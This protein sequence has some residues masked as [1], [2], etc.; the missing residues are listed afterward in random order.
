MRQDL[1]N[2]KS[3]SK[4]GVLA[5]RVA[6]DIVILFS[7]HTLLKLCRRKKNARLLLT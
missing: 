5:I 3:S 2:Q 6:V 1:R 7:S 4:L